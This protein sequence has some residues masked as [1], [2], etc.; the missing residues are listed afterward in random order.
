MANTILTA[1]EIATIAA[2][3]AGQDLGLAALFSRDVEA[4]FGGGTGA[5][6][7]VRVPGAVQAHERSA[8]DKTTPLAVDEIVEQSI[9]VTLD[10]LVY[11]NVP[12]SVG[13][14]ELNIVDFGVQ[15]LKPQT[16]AIVKNIEAQA[17]AALVATPATTV[18]YAAATPAK[19][20]TKL[21]STLRAN[22]VSSGARMRAAVGSDVWADLLDGP[23]GTFDEGGKTVRGVEVYESTRIPAKEVVAFI[24]EAFSLVVRAPQVP[25][26]APFGASVKSGG[27]ALTHLQTF[28]SAT[29]SDRSIVE[30][31]VAVTAMPLAVDN[32]DGTVD[33]V[34]HGGAVRIVT[35]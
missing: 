32:E 8:F 13:D 16:S 6:I 29:A 31:L 14:Q 24:P 7:R 22:G 21:R 20:F 34:E 17:A 4:D 25:A 1:D 28:D 35:S 9:P 3:L 33:L 27:F 12:L 10:T 11:S 15:I 2:S 18:T 19:A 5:T 26:G 23:L 30:A